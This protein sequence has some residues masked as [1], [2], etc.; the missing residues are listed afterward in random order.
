PSADA[1]KDHFDAHKDTYTIPEKRE[2]LAVFIKTEDLKK[3]IELSDKE[4]E[5]YYQDNLSRFTSPETT[6]VG[7]IWMPFTETDKAKVEAEAASVLDRLRKGAAF[8]DLAKV[9]SKDAKAQ[10]GGDYGLYDWKSLPQVERDDIAR[11]TAG[12]TSNLITEAGGIAILK[13]AM[14]T[15]SSTT[16][17]A[18]AK[19]QIRTALLDEKARALAGERIAKIQKDAKSAKSLEAALKK[20]NLKTASTGLLKS[21]EAWGENDPSGVVSSAL[22][23]LKEKE[24]SSPLYAYAGVGLAELR[25]IEAPRPATFDEVKA[26]V[27]TALANERKKAKALAVLRDVR[28]RL[29]DKNWEDLAAQNKLEFKN[30]EA[31]KR[32]QY[33]A[34]IGESKEADDLAFGLP[35]GQTSDPFA[36]ENGYALLRVIDRK[37]S[38][39]AEFDKTKDIETERFLA[40][41]KNEFLQSYLAKLREEKGVQIKYDRFVQVTQD[42]LERYAASE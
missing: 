31:H 27:E 30:V 12:E 20:A 36:F 25:K 21:G 17:L 24:I 6:Q 23:G 39:R 8:A 7:R 40:T 18:E 13:V 38:S 10:A 37:E 5:Q 19:P 32:E 22:F 1:I 26:D 4:I 2:G 33:I 16:P 11:L 41:A 28:A 29:T 9:Y 3:E 34:V 15:A 42:V 35:V 14:K